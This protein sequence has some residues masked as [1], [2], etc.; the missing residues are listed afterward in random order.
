[1]KAF[2]SLLSYQVRPLLD[3]YSTVQRIVSLPFRRV[4]N[5]RLVRVHPGPL[6][7]VSTT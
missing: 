1:M 2:L 5:D 3:H 6:S 7:L 4:D